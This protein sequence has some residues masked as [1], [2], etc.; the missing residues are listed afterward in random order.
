M[1]LPDWNIWE[2][3]QYNQ[4]RHLLEA[5]NKSSYINIY[6]NLYPYK[7]KVYIL[8][9]EV[10]STF[11]AQNLKYRNTRTI[12]SADTPTGFLK[13]WWYWF[14]EVCV[15]KLLPCLRNKMKE[16]NKLSDKNVLRPHKKNCNMQICKVLE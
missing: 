15:P 7:R 11:F 4:H 5:E 2:E 16:D 13:Y 10:I 3:Y 1:C 12:E 14:T 8:D 9:I 6:Q